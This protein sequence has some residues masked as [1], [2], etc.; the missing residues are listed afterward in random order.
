MGVEIEDAFQVASLIGT[1]VF[2]DEFISFINLNEMVCL[3]RIKVIYWSYFQS[4]DVSRP[5]PWSLY[6]YVQY[7]HNIVYV[8]VRVCMCRVGQKW[9]VLKVLTPV[10]VAIE[11]RSI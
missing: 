4:S 1:K 3:R 8:C 7:M 6:T 2:A 10:C 11:K 5:H 9:T